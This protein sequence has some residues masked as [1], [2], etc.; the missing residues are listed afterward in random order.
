MAEPQEYLLKE[1]SRRAVDRQRPD[2]GNTAG[3]KGFRSRPRGRGTT[4]PTGEKGALA[5]NGEEARGR[6][7]ARLLCALTGRAYQTGGGTV[8]RQLDLD[9]RSVGLA[10]I[11]SDP[12]MT[13]DPRIEACRARA[14][15]IRALADDFRAHASDTMLEDF[16]TLMM[17]TARELDTEAD[18]IFRSVSGARPSSC[19]LPS[20]FP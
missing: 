7:L 11:V 4:Q 14:R 19:T 13:S 17:R 18:R 2:D 9:Q 3:K 12:T 15:K 8:S 10:V 1:A 16:A 6:N 5:L 20:C